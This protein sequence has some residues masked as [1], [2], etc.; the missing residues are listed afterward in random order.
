MS[1]VKS[2]ST[3]SDTQIPLKK[4]KTNIESDETFSGHIDMNVEMANQLYDNMQEKIKPLITSLEEIEFFDR[5]N[6]TH[7]LF[8]KL[9]LYTNKQKKLID[10][11]NTPFYGRTDSEHS[12]LQAAGFYTD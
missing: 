11:A 7:D 10:M 4:Q 3:K 1:V 5:T 6:K 9:N 12:A 8:I 2:K